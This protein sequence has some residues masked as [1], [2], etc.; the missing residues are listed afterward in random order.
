ML[1]FIVMLISFRVNQCIL[2]ISTCFQMYIIIYILP[3]GWLQQVHRDSLFPLFLF[4]IL[5]RVFASCFSIINKF[6][7]WVSS[8]SFLISFSLSEEFQLVGVV[9]LELVNQLLRKK[10]E[11]K[12][13]TNRGRNTTNKGPTTKWETTNLICFFLFFSFVPK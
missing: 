2:F 11:R 7:K 12:K 8:F 3:I 5:L 13:S 6:T 1:L 4:R 10:N 9:V